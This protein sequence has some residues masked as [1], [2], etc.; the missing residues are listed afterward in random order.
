MTMIFKSANENIFFK[1]NSAEVIEFLIYYDS[2]TK[3]LW[4]VNQ[5]LGCAAGVVQRSVAS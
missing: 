1:S 2:I 5:L 4:H 3:V